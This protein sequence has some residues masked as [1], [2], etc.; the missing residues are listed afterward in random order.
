MFLENFTPLANNF[1][2]P[3]AVTA[4][5]NLTSDVAVLHLDHAG[6]QQ[7]Q[8]ERSRPVS[9]SRTAEICKELV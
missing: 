8:L 4:V 9:S 2:L 7:A 5:T 6:S 3:A 1:T